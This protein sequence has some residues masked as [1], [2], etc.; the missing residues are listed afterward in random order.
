M[1]NANKKRFRRGDPLVFKEKPTNLTNVR[2][3]Q[4]KGQKEVYSLSNSKPLSEKTIKNM[5]RIYLKAVKRI[6]KIRPDIIFNDIGILY[7]MCQIK[8]EESKQSH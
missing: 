3:Y 1:T 4:I 7:E 5:K 6:R 2:M 8:T